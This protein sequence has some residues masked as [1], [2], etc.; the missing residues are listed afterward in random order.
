[1]NLFLSDIRIWLASWLPISQLVSCSDD[2]APCTTNFPTYVLPVKGMTLRK[3]SQGDMKTADTKEQ[4]R[5]SDSCNFVQVNNHIRL[6]SPWR[7]E[8]HISQ[9][10]S[11][12][13]E[14]AKHELAVIP[15]DEP[16]SK[17]MY[18][19]MHQISIFFVGIDPFG[20]VLFVTIKWPFKQW[21][22]LCG[23]LFVED[24]KTDWYL[25]KSLK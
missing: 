24:H 11:K 10:S 13:V 4:K 23:L 21:A 16:V 7:Y 22:I 5:S 15:F 17:P 8:S 18:Y 1:M 14:I 25:Q 19:F 3:S 20:N 2:Q 9:S 12:T 6:V